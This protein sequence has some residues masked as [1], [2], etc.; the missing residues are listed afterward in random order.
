MRQVKEGRGVQGHED[1]IR[2][3]I[4]DSENSKINVTNKMK[5]IENEAMLMKQRIQEH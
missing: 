5:A 2:K 1:N 3:Q 4:M